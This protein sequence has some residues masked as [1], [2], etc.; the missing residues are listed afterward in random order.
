MTFGIPVLIVYLL[1][2]VRHAAAGLKR[3]TNPAEYHVAGRRVPG[4][5]IGLSF[6]ATFLSTNSFVGL[7]G[8]SAEFGL[9]TWLIGL[10][11]VGFAWISWRFIAPPLR[12]ASERFGSLSL[13]EFFGSAYDAA[14]YR[15]LA[16]VVV[17]VASIP[18][19]Q[20]VFKGATLVVARLS[21]L[22]EGPA[23]LILWIAVVAYTLCGGF[24]AVVR[25]DVVQG[26]LMLFAALLLPVLLIVHSGGLGPLISATEAAS[27]RPAS[28]WPTMAPFSLL[29]A[30]GCAGGFKLMAEPRQVTRFFAVD[31]AE[32]G[33]A[34]RTALVALLI[35]YVALLPVGL[36]AHGV[37]T[38]LPTDVDQI[39]P[40]LLATEDVVPPLAGALILGSLLAAA[41]SSI[42][43]AL[44]VVGAALQRDILRWEGGRGPLDELL[45]TRLFVLL[46]SIPPALLVFS[47]DAEIL[48]LTT[49]AG[50]LYGAAF[51]VPLLFAVGPRPERRAAWAATLA[52]IGSLLL[53]KI[54][55]IPAFPSTSVVHEVIVGAAA[56]FLAM[57]TVITTR[58][59]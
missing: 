17:V 4:V 37:L 28:A 53:W 58:R 55:V 32:I 20:A 46:A 43:S 56:S 12:A 44:L 14:G 19:L 48:D 36:L 1:L 34:R 49:F 41:M 8:R 27:G 57:I 24:H 13:P 9:G 45:S 38:E 29:L 22:D 16:G 15:R 30:M 11:F 25:T 59:A 52:G 6:Y 40:A 26:A 7:T 2:M 23:L 31:A 47:T 33:K 21:G 50:G 42:D 10:M 18:Y 3:S 51:L 5:L 39:I 54:V 35:S